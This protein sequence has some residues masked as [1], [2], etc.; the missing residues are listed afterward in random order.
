MR[1]LFFLGSN[2]LYIYI[3]IYKKILQ[4]KKNQIQEINNK[5]QQH[6]TLQNKTR[7]QK[8]KSQNLKLTKHPIPFNNRILNSITQRK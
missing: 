6:L 2:T 8:S 4:N 3:Y 1:F 5:N 7:V